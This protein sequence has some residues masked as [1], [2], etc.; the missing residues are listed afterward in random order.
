MALYNVSCPG[1]GD[2]PSQP[3]YVTANSPEHSIE[4]HSNSKKHKEFE[5]RLKEF[6]SAKENK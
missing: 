5:G 1:C 2:T 3:N 4:V 6:H